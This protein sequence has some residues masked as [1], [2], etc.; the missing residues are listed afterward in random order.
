MSH[1]KKTCPGPGSE[2]HGVIV[3][4]YGI[5]VDVLFESGDRQKV[6]VKRRSGHVVGDRVVLRGHRLD[7]K[8]RR[9]ELCRRDSRGSVRVVG[10]NLDVV[11]IVVSPLPE[12]TPGYID[13]AV[14]CAR[15]ADLVPVLV[16][17]KSDLAE[18]PAFIRKLHGIYGDV[19]DI[20]EVSA[21]YGYGLDR[22]TKWLGQGRRGFF[23]GVSGVGKSSLL[24]AICPK[25]DL[26]VGEIYAA[27]RRGCNKTT[28]STLHALPGGGELVDTPGF[29]EFGLVDITPDTLADV[30]P[31]LEPVPPGSCR[32]RN[33]RHRTE[34]GCAVSSMVEK[35][36]IARERYDAYV[37]TLDLVEAG[38]ARFYGRR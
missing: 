27:G 23:V 14:V 25:L 5:A 37:Y 4:H 28:V 19:L 10:A 24:N 34:P 29:N 26:D 11:G 13:Q 1:N 30:F 17:N 38:E 35:G 36:G 16:A 21:L 3:A 6:K 12:P 22:L 15:Q 31:G 7:R 33:C 2:N 9:T 20:F 18:A 8:E 32:F